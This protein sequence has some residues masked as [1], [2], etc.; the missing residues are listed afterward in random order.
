MKNIHTCASYRFAS[1]TYGRPLGISDKDCNISQPEDVLED[2]RFREPGGPDRH[3]CVC[4]SAYQ[5]EL[6]KLYQIAS[7]AIENV[8]S[9]PQSAHP[10]PASDD[11][12]LVRDVTLRL[13]TW[14]RSLPEQLALRLEKDCSRTLDT[15]ARAHCLQSLSLHLTFDSLIIVLHRPFIKHRFDLVTTDTS[16]QTPSSVGSQAFHVTRSENEQSSPSVVSEASLELDTSSHQ[17]WWQAA[18]RTS[19]AGNGT[20]TAG[21]DCDRQSF[22]RIPS[23]QLVQCCYGYGCGSTLGSVDQQCAREAKRAVARIYRLQE[24]LGSRSTL[25]EQS[26]RVLRSLVEL[27]LRRESDA[28]LAPVAQVENIPS[29]DDQSQVNQ[30][31]PTRP[32]VQDALSMPLGARFDQVDNATVA[33]ANKGLGLAS[34]LNHSLATVQKSILTRLIYSKGFADSLKLS[35]S[36][37]NENLTVDMPVYSSRATS[38]GH[39]RADPSNTAATEGSIMDQTSFRP[40]VGDWNNGN[41]IGDGGL[42]WFWDPTWDDLYNSIHL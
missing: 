8:Y 30:S 7:P 26:S 6:N 40:D 25:S 15:D 1:I 18:V 34:R 28:I 22:G 21:S 19:G 2:T 4:F 16:R 12:S 11:L 5:R 27:L 32:S 42:Y 39:F 20:A 13:W 24:T 10:R 33:Q 36:A 37:P 17:Q 3:A 38:E 29:R 23:N 31:N 35:P 41:A 9:A 14:R